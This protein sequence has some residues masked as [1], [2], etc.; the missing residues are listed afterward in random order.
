[1]T[2]LFAHHPGLETIDH[3]D[4]MMFVQIFLAGAIGLGFLMLLSSSFLYNSHPNHHR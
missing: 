2:Y 4:P 1:M 3:F